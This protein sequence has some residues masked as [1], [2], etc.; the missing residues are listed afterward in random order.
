MDFINMDLGEFMVYI[1]FV[2]IASKRLVLDDAN[3]QLGEITLQ[4][5]CSGAR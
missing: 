1:D 4:G 2:T 3:H 5:L